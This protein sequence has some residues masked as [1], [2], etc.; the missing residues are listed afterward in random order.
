MFSGSVVLGLPKFEDKGPFMKHVLGDWQLTTI[1]QAGTGYPITVNLGVAGINAGHGQQR[2]SARTARTMAPATGRCTITRTNRTQ[3][4][5][6]SAFT[7]NGRVLGT[8]GNSSALR[9]RGPFMFQADASV[10][11]NI[12]LGPRVTLQLRLEVFNI[13]N[14]VNFRSD[15]LNTT[16]NAEN[17]VYGDAAGNVV[18]G[19]SPARYPG[20]ERDAVQQLRSVQ[21]GS[22]PEDDAGRTFA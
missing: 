15:A 9:V 2:L 13:F 3:Y 10:Y 22:R 8:N 12:H 1:V 16:W 5:N 6:A 19:N 7:I 17:V 20:P 18:A 11:K 14:N 21:P 4:L